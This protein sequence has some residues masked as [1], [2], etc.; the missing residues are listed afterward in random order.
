MLVASIWVKKAKADG[1]TFTPRAY[2]KQQLEN[3]GKIDK[4]K[5]T[6][7]RLK[8]AESLQNTQIKEPVSIKAAKT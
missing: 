3:Q 5:Y 7:C 8:K 1:Y 4:K 6:T 2:T